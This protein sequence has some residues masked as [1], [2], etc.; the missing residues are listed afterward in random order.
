MGFP[1]SFIT[2]DK[3]FQ[4][5]PLTSGQRHL[6]WLLSQS[7]NNR[8]PTLVLIDEPEISLHIEWQRKLV[9][10]MMSISARKKTLGLWEQSFW[11]PRRTD[12][13]IP[14]RII[15]ATHSPD[16]LL[17]HIERGVEIQGRK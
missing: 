12:D 11:V 14:P 1:T 8:H 16:I 2:Q 13:S 4:Q 6:I 7:W 17:N 3:D 15:M 9:D 5:E 10:Y